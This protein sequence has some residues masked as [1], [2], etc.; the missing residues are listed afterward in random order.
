MYSSE[1][2]SD[3]GPQELKGRTRGIQSGMIRPS[4]QEGP[5]ISLRMNQSIMRI[6][7]FEQPWKLRLDLHTSSFKTP[8]RTSWFGCCSWRLGSL[9]GWRPGAKAADRRRMTCTALRSLVRGSHGSPPGHFP[10][11]VPA[12]SSLEC[13]PEPEQLPR[14]VCSQPPLVYYFLVFC[15][16]PTLFF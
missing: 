8:S 12:L 4:F 2:A 11:L 13:Y 9:I 10:N 1:S 6:V 15:T 14:F 5:D 3:A 16:Y 7:G